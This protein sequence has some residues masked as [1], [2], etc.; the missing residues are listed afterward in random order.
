MSLI[1][2]KYNV[3]DVITQSYQYGSDANG[4]VCSVI[5]ISSFNLYDSN[6]INIGYVEFIDNGVATKSTNNFQNS[7]Q[8][9]NEIGCFF[10]KD[11]GTITYNISFESSSSSFE[12]NLVIPTIISD[13]GIYYR[14]TDQIV[15]NPFSDGRRNVWISLK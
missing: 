1:Q 6:N 12:S 8:L 15:I 5:N 13:T 11:K 9:Y 14:K 4:N 2:F 3:N 10:I 7:D